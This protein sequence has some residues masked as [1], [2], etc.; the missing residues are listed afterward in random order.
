MNVVKWLSV[1]VIICIVVGLVALST[2]LYLVVQ[3]NPW[4][5]SLIL[6]R[7]MNGGGLARA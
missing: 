1:R 6:R 4:P 7:A 2:A 3:F 5:S